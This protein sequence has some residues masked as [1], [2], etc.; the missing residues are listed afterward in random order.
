MH[1]NYIYIEPLTHQT[2]FLQGW[3][4]TRPQVKSSPNQLGPKSTWA[5]VRLTL[6]PSWYGAELTW[7]RADCKP[8]LHCRQQ[9]KAQ[10]NKQIITKTKTHRPSSTKKPA[11]TKCSST[12]TF[13]SAFMWYLYTLT[14]ASHKHCQSEMQD[15]RLAAVRCNG[16]ARTCATGWQKYKLRSGLQ[17]PQLGIITDG[18]SFACGRYTT[19]TCNCLAHV[20]QRWHNIRPYCYMAIFCHMEPDKN[21]KNECGNSCGIIPTWFQAHVYVHMNWHTCHTCT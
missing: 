4:S 1:K 21:G 10:N 13:P 6:Q 11:K 12:K 16:L 5:R 3:M 9:K 18:W 7:R 20:T 19:L 17:L 14:T 8:F 15:S 2:V